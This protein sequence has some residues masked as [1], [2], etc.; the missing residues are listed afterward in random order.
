MHRYGTTDF[1]CITVSGY[2]RVLS[3]EFTEGKKPPPEEAGKETDGFQVARLR[4]GPD[5]PPAACSAL[6]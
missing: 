6:P 3:I 4:F 2:N 1:V 5:Q